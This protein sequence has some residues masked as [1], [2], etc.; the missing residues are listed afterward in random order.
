MEKEQRILRVI[1]LNDNYTVIH[2]V[3]SRNGND[4]WSLIAGEF[5]I[6]DDGTICCEISYECNSFES[7]LEKFANH[8]SYEYMVKSQVDIAVSVYRAL[9]EHK[10]YI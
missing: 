9:K 4:F 2:K 5:E 10:D 8:S 6:K 1:K 7:C 3:I